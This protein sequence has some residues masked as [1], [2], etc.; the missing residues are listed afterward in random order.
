MIAHGKCI[1]LDTTYCAYTFTTTC[2]LEDAKFAAVKGGC[3]Y[4]M[5][6]EYYNKFKMKMN[7]VDALKLLDSLYGYMLLNIIEEYQ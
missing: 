1:L 2:L 4:A 7:Q 6:K 5:Q 3:T